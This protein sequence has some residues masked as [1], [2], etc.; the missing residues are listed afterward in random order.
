MQSARVAS[1][2]SLVPRANTRSPLPLIP[3][4]FIATRSP[5]TITRMT[6]LYG[7][8][9]AGVLPLTMRM[10]SA[11]PPTSPALRSV[12]LSLLGTL[13]LLTIV[14]F[15]FKS[16]PMT[17]TAQPQTMTTLMTWSCNSSSCVGATTLAGASCYVPEPY[18]SFLWTA[19]PLLRHLHYLT[20]ALTTLCLLLF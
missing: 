5:P 1:T 20:I 17:C 3:T 12:A 6:V 19:P 9:A 7:R 14:Q 16:I 15:H 13:A 4:V 11:P 2:P 8:F 18:F 10:M